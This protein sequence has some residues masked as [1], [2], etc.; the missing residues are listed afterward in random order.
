MKAGWHWL[1]L[2]ER[3]VCVRFLIIREVYLN[4]IYSNSCLLKKLQKF[5]GFIIDIHTL[6]YYLDL[7][8]T[9]VDFRTTWTKQSDYR[10]KLQKIKNK[11][12]IRYGD[13]VIP[14]MFDKNI[15]WLK[16]LGRISRIWIYKN[17]KENGKNKIK[18]F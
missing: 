15:G 5:Y 7:R 18:L 16:N 13:K 14:V 1:T 17:A 4:F 12:T 2:L 10:N 8:I 6:I 3:R 9:W 11:Y